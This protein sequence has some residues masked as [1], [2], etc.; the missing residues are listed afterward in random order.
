ML[1]WVCEDWSTN[2]ELFTVKL[3]APGKI[4]MVEEKEG[5][6]SRRSLASKVTKPSAG[7]IDA[8]FFL[9]RNAWCLA[10]VTEFLPRPA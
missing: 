8:V 6:A 3:R 10:P 9:V 4:A 2:S 7:N 1:I 5:I